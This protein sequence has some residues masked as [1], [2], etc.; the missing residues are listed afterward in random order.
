[1]PLLLPSILSN[2]ARTQQPFILLQS[3]LAQSCL[4]VLRNIIAQSRSKVLLF[5]FL[6]P[7]S[8]LLADDIAT[9]TEQLEVFDLTDR[10]PGYSDE[11]ADCRQYILDIMNKSVS[12]SRCHC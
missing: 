3:S 9:S 1:M 5:C 4:S 11:P 6:Y 2:A 7:P 8:A 10:I 12:R